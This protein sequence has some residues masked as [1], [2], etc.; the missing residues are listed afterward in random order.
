MNDASAT[1]LQLVHARVLL[2]CEC[3]RYL[4]LQ[5]YTNS[6][7]DMQWCASLAARPGLTSLTLGNLAADAHVLNGL[8][9]ALTGLRRLSC[10]MLTSQVHH[11]SLAANERQIVADELA[12]RNVEAVGPMTCRMQTCLT[13]CVMRYSECLV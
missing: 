9:P 12:P 13:S 2:A 7:N 3:R 8:W 5:P 11:H 1:A 4:L 6:E 10:H